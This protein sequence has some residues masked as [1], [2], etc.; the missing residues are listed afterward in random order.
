MAKRYEDNVIELAK[1]HRVLRIPFLGLWEGNLRIKELKF[2]F[3]NT[4]GFIRFT[5]ESWNRGIRLFFQDVA[6]Q[7][8]GGIQELITGND[9]KELLA[10]A[11][12]FLGD[13]WPTYSA[14]DLGD[15]I[16]DMQ[17]SNAVQIVFKK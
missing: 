13:R 9:Y 7:S 14:D 17:E 15:F 16:N 3:K 8:N 11:E 1:K 12:R 6:I 4:T 2:W 5:P 10:R